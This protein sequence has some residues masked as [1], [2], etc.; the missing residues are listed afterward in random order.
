MTAAV[1]AVVFDFDGTIVDTETPVYEAWAAAY[2]FAGVE[3]VPLE[4]WLQD[5]GKADGQGLDVRALLC[6]QLGV[7]EMPED[8]EAHRQATRDAMVHAQPIRD[9]VRAW[10]DAAHSSGI[11]LAV[12][13]SSSSAWVVPHLER[14]G[15][16]TYF[17]AV[18]CADPGIPGKP[19]P[20]VYLR[21]C[22][23]LA[24]EP[25]ESLAIEDSTHGV[26][27]A[28]AAGMRC[29]AAPGPM[30]TSMDFSHSTMRV[31][32]LADLAPSD[33]LETSD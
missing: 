16:D 8:A 11:R 14:L 9:G 7:S 31:D 25:G 22:A 3:P 21:A 29:I 30:T 15:L 26:S 18:S 17:S 1:R 12:A 20:T 33:W 24:V 2:R 28:I 6:E 10:L 13:S 27:A 4:R 19:D 32:S 23:D 5:L